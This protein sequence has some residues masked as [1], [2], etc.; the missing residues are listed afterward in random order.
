[1]KFKL[2][3][4]LTLF[5]AAV[6]FTSC[7]SD[8]DAALDTQKP[9]IAITE[10]NNDEELAPGGEVHFVAVFTD[11]VALASYKIE[12]HDDFDDHTHAQAKNTHDVNPWSFEQVYT[13]PAGQTSF[14]ADE[15]IDIPITFN[16]EPISEGI[17]H[18]GIYVTDTS[19]NEEQAF[20]SIH[21]EGEHTEEGQSHDE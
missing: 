11:N 1:M 16:G 5:I 15:H 17:Y 10:P 2:K 21:I 8:D 9:T 19:G 13:I 6:L 7:S 20:L 12:I 4:I 18:F 14:N 3:S